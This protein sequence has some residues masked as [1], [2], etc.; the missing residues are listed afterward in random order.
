MP[1]NPTERAKKKAG[2]TL[3]A[4]RKTEEDAISAAKS[5]FRMEGVEGEGL[6][7]EVKK[8]GS[9][10]HSD[11]RASAKKAHQHLK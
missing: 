1:D 8:A 9:K 3:D 10:V 6:M 2:M 5:T 11:P 4:T 7:D